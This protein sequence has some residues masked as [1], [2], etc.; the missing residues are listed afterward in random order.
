MPELATEACKII[1]QQEFDYF[2]SESAARDHIVFEGLDPSDLST[3]ELG[4]TKVPRIYSSNLDIN[5]NDAFKTLGA[6]EE[7]DFVHIDRYGITL[8]RTPEGDGYDAGIDL[9][10]PSHGRSCSL[11]LRSATSS[12]FSL[13]PK[14]GD[15]T[16]EASRGKPIELPL[17]K[18]VLLADSSEDDYSS[19]VYD[20]F[21]DW[22]RVLIVGDA[23]IK[24][25]I[26]MNWYEEKGEHVTQ[27]QLGARI[28]QVGLIL[29][30]EKA[31]SL[32][33]DFRSVLGD[34][35]VMERALS[36]IS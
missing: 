16:L 29:A 9:L 32:D 31:L 4:Y 28:G 8:G 1:T 22:E 34:R 33:T 12:T 20:S 13:Q 30:L 36:S 24:K 7:Q 21:R 27:K 25:Y 18:N 6:P 23:A 26:Y 2:E 10:L 17:G 5:L 19:A 3:T 35:S 15:K 11:R 14:Q